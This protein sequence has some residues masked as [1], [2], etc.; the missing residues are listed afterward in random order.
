MISI[1]FKN[2]PIFIILLTNLISGIAQG[3]TVII[4]PW[5]F[6][7]T[8]NT[9]S[10]FSLFYGILTFIGLFWGLYAGVIIDNFNR[11]NI[12]LMIN[13]IS[14]II[15]G[16]IALAISHFSA[17]IKYCAL[18]AFG[19]CS[20][21]YTIFFPNLYALVQEIINKKH[22][23]KINS[24]LE[25]QLQIT[26]IIAAITCAVLMS[27][28][29]INNVLGVEIDL[30]IEKWELSSIFLI[31]SIMYL[32]STFLVFFLNYKKPKIKKFNIFN[33][34][35]DIKKGGVYLKNHPDITVYGICS[36]IIFAFLIVELFALLPTFVKSC[37]NGSIIM[38]SLADLTY[39][40]GAIISGLILSKVIKQVNT[41]LATLIF[42]LITGYSFWMMIA[43]H[44]VFIFF[45][46]TL[47]IGMT[48]AGTRIIR[49]TYLLNKVPNNIIG[50]INTI[51]NGINTIIR[52]ILIMIFAIPW[53]TYNQNVITGYRIGVLILI[54]FIVPLIW[55]YNQK[56]V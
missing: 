46:S 2:P 22:Y 56:K 36:Q 50:R 17:E 23:I 26:S 33:T 37:L 34:L 1:I 53:F 49:M 38:F 25:I 20:L 18:L 43:F 8:L 24:I 16:F 39:A 52:S 29:Q 13:L 15:F 6:T 3:L 10:T 44:N 11:K 35:S 54:V 28:L 14:S 45:I 4:I 21:Y 48:N 41:I 7:D 40:I 30:K 12:L 51:F 5:Y 31:N 19:C 42:I 55:Q 9:S 27:N 32:V 47:I